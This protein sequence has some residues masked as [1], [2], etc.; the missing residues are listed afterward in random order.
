[1]GRNAIPDARNKMGMAPQ[2]DQYSTQPVRT[3]GAQGG[4]MNTMGAA[5]DGPGNYKNLMQL[6]MEQNYPQQGQQPQAGQQPTPSMDTGPWGGGQSWAPLGG[7]QQAQ[8]S[9]P[10]TGYGWGDWN[11]WKSIDPQA[12]ANFGQM[13]PWEQLRQNS[14]QYGMDFNEAQRRW[15]DQFGWQQQNDRFSQGLAGRQ[16]DMAEWVSRQQQGNW[17][18]QFGFDQEMGRGQ[19]QLGNREAEI[20]D[21]YQRNQV[22]I[23]QEQNRIDDMWKRG[24]L[25]AQQREMALAE[26]KQRQDESFRRTQLGQEASLTRENYANQQA[27]ARMQAFGRTQTP[28]SRWVRSW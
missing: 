16:Q 25:S 9:S 2:P 21:W 22:G 20:R 8:Y 10:F 6:W 15:N 12:V 1:M 18:K 23:G 7:G 4:Q 13:L 5:N 3:Q 24:Q 27:I 14:Y 26:L 19:L 17:D 28:N 11:T